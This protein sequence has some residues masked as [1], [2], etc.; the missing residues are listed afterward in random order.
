MSI[1]LPLNGR[2]MSTNSR[3]WK[4]S[5]LFFQCFSFWD[6]PLSSRD[7]WGGGDVAAQ[8]CFRCYL[9]RPAPRPPEI[10]MMLTTQ[11]VMLRMLMLSSWFVILVFFKVISSYYE[12]LSVLIV[13]VD[14]VQFTC[15]SI[16]KLNLNRKS[17]T[18]GKINFHRLIPRR[19]GLL[20]VI[21][22]CRSQICHINLFSELAP[23]RKPM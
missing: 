7:I 4:K 3:S 9:P 1:K 10:T 20:C 17:R 23:D 21:E 15:P 11:M 19:I 16:S 8:R 22:G 2:S 13:Q 5:F 6:E 14:I 12:D 18:S